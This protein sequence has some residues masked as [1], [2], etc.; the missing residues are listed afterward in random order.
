M[1]KHVTRSILL[2]VGDDGSVVMAVSNLCEHE[3]IT[4]L[5]V[6]ARSLIEAIEAREAQARRN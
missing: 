2:S 5:T 3:V 4:V 1:S 6:T